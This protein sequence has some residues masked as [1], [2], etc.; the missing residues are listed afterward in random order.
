MSAIEE[1]GAVARHN[2][3]RAAHS[4]ELVR[5]LLGERLNEARHG[6]ARMM[7]RMSAIKANSGKIA[8]ILSTIDT[9]A[10]QTNILALNAAIEAA[11]AGDAGLGFGVVAGEVRAL[12]QRCATAAQDTRQLVEISTEG[13]EQAA[14]RMQNLNGEIAAIVEEAGRFRQMFDEIQRG[15]REQSESISQVG[16]AQ[17]QTDRA[18][19]EVARIAKQSAEAGHALREQSRELNGMVAAL[20]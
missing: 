9:I 5:Q 10:F 18:A 3:E 16:N 20:K 1:I 19:Q 12:A 14:S 6:A 13:S 17:R 2:A 4:A 15:S 7:E 11:R 8:E